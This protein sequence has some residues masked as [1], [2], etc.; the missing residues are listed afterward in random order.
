MILVSRFFSFTFVL[1]SCS[2][3]PDKVIKQVDAP[4]GY[5][6]NDWDGPP[7]DVITY[8]PPD[9][10][11]KTP[12]LCNTW[13]IQRRPKVPCFLVRPCKKKNHFSVLTIGAKKSFSQMNTLIM[14]EV[15][16]LVMVL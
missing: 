2:S 14:Q 9:A 10:T 13:S 5:V 7:I 8:I 12:L 11:E 16:Y 15:L 4:W 1:F 6:F 3:T